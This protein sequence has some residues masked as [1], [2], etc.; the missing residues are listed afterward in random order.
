MWYRYINY[1]RS[2]VRERKDYTA[3]HICF[4]EVTRQLV[5]KENSLG[6]ELLTKMVLKVDKRNII[7]LYYIT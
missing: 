4:I 6:E 7:A 3:T 1:V 5:Y 2:F